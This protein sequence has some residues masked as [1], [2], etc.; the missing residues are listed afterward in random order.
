MVRVLLSLGRFGCCS[1]GF[2]PGALRGSLDLA[3]LQPLGANLDVFNR[4]IFNDLHGLKIG[5]EAAGGDAGGLQAN[6]AGSL[7][8]TAAG[9]SL[10]ELGLFAREI[11][12]SGHAFLLR[13]KGQFSMVRR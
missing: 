12:N 8:D 7:R 4:T 6:T 9:D 5:R 13:M 11:A 2:L 10:A 1:F 3:R